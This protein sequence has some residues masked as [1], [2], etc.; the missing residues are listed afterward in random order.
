MEYEVDNRLVLSTEREYESLYSWSLKEFDK[1]GKQVG[2]DQIPWSWTLQ[3]DVT[4]LVP[5]LKVR[6]NN[7]EQDDEVA[8][9]TNGEKVTSEYLFG[10]LK[11]A[12]E[13]RASG[14]YSMFGSN[15]RIDNFSFFVYPV[16]DNEKARCDVCGSISYTADF[17]F[18]NRTQP[19]WVQFNIYLPLT[20]FHEIMRVA[21]LRIATNVAIRVSGVSGFY[22]E[23]S[24]S[25]RADMIKV[26]A[27]KTDQRLENPGS[28]TI[29][30]PVLGKVREFELTFSQKYSLANPIER[31]EG[32]D[33]EHTSPSPTQNNLI[34][35][36]RGDISAL[37]KQI[38]LLTSGLGPL[39]LAIWLILGAVILL[40]IK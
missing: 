8:P 27:N 25:I 33:D 31:D 37:Q 26:L 4:E 17:D 24:P 36:N 40:I 13:R 11:P 9:V 7:E 30:P 23:W 29:D 10:N 6:I 28:L 3:F 32:P 39:K 35:D 21:R 12:S 16:N 22:S 1:A 18:E 20:R 2:R 15:R 38:S 34:A 19:D 14:I 5:V